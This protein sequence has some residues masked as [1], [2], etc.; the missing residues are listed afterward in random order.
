[1][2][3]I[4]LNDTRKKTIKTSEKNNARQNFTKSFYSSGIPI[5]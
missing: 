3:L 1:M 4:D 2:N 5:K